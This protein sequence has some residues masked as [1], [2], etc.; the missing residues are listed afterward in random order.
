[1]RVMSS[2]YSYVLQDWRGWME[3][4]ILD[5]A[6]PMAYRHHDTALGAAQYEGWA[7]RAKEFQYDRAAAVG[8]GFYLNSIAD[9]LAQIG[10]AGEATPGTL[11]SAAGSVGFSYAVATDTG[12]SRQTFLDALTD[13]V[14]AE[15]FTPGQAPL[16]AQPVAVPAQP[17]KT[18]TALGHLAGSVRDGSNGM[19]L[20]GALVTLTGPENRVF[21][22]DGTGFL[23]AVGLAPGVYLL[24]ISHPGLS[25]FAQAVTISGGEVAL[26]D[27]MLVP[28][29]AAF[30]GITLL[31][32]PL[33]VIVSWP[34]KSGCRYTVD[35]SSDL[36]IWDTL[37]SGI[38][39]AVNLMN[40]FQDS[41]PTSA[42]KRY[43][44]VVETS[45]CR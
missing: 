7:L 13:P 11:L 3:E 5:L 29:S 15:M 14:T 34:S 41:P 37:A 28:S 6:I 18:E 9:N 31:E 20:D 38:P 23:G 32:D 40:T 24:R 33:R 45:P 1:M 27:A 17:W 44:R 4:G 43:Y 42:E 8:I 21:T 12:T 22:S 19:P 25:D 26:T 30:D 36:E 35:T 39:A 10:I 16:F 2:A